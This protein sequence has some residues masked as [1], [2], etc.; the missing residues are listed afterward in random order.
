MVRAQPLNGRRRSPGGLG[1]DRQDDRHVQISHDEL[2]NPITA[3]SLTSMDKQIKVYLQI[4]F[5]I[6]L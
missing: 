1:I 4:F 5:N 6:M 2:D 3:L